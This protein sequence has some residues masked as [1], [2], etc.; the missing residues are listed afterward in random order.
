MSGTT[1]S[2]MWLV[3]RQRRTLPVACSLLLLLLPLPEVQSYTVTRT[4]TA[5]DHRVVDKFIM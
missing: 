1:V 4:E 3:F 2:V 5:G